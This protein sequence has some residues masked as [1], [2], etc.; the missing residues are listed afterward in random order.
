MKAEVVHIRWFWN[1]DNRTELVTPS[2]IWG[3]PN[4]ITAIGGN[5]FRSGNKITS[6][7][8]PDSVKNIGEYNSRFDS[9]TNVI[10]GANVE[11]GGNRYSQFN[12]GFKNFYNENRRQA[13]TY[14]FSGNRW[15][16]RR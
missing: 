14:T 11:I 12:E 7:T 1:E 4:A 9:L 8:I 15:N 6:L 13:G 5:A 3:E 2:E 16:Y 10:I